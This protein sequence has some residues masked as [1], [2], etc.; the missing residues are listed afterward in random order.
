MSI[1]GDCVVWD[2]VGNVSTLSTVNVGY[3]PTQYT[4]LDNDCLIVSL[5]TSG[6]YPFLNVRPKLKIGKILRFACSNL[7][8]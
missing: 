8:S 1:A 5:A 6:E 4:L 3:N 2:V 7:G